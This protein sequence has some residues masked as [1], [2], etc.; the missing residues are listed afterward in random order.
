ML[1]MNENI[2]LSFSKS[3]IQVCRNRR[4]RNSSFKKPRRSSSS[5]LFSAYWI[6][7]SNSLMKKGSEYWYIGSMF[8]RSWIVKNKPAVFRATG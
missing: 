3:E 1:S 5:S 6:E 8:A 7:L 2:N 4:S